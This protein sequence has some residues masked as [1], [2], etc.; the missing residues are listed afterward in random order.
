[1]T[2]IRA[3]ALLR[4]HE[5]LAGALGAWTPTMRPRSLGAYLVVRG[6]EHALAARRPDTGAARLLDAGYLEAMID[7]RI[8]PRARRLW[9][10]L[11]GPPDG[12]AYLH[13]DP[14]APLDRVRALFVRATLCDEAG[15]WDTALVLHERHAAALEALGGEPREIAAALARV[16]VANLHRGAYDE[17]LRVAERAVERSAHE[18]SG[19]TH[20]Q[21]LNVLAGA[22]AELGDLDGAL[23]THRELA[24]RHGE[25]APPRLVDVAQNRNN[26][27]LLL[28]SLDRP[29]EALDEATRASE[30]LHALGEPH[31]AEL[32]TST[33]TLAAVH[34]ALGHLDE[35]L[36]LFRSLAA[37]ELARVGREHPAAIAAQNN[38]AVHVLNH[39]DPV[40]ADALFSDLVPA[41]R[42]TFGADHPN[43]LMTVHAASLAAE[44]AGRYEHAEELARDALQRRRAT[45]RIEHPATRA[46]LRRL[47]GLLASQARHDERAALWIAALDE[48]AASLPA[49]H[50][51]CTEARA[52]LA[53]VWHELRRYA[54]AAS[55]F[56][57][58]VADREAALGL[59]H[60]STLAARSNLARA[61]LHAGETLEAEALHQE[62]M[63]TCRRAFG[64]DHDNTHLVEERWRRAR[65]E[66]A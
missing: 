27:A 49:D 36:A 59:E 12:S 58:V 50:A 26:A 29:R 52:G 17:A 62:L 39:G 63:A 5:Q 37:S 6:V 66:P 33:S 7:A 46:S 3:H 42:A 53:A 38:L 10:A 35:A 13:G 34:Q 54:E 32:A 48:C 41:C 18:P 1:M 65:G 51:A 40:E 47:D 55:L 16:A 11:G 9:K 30:A 25:A 23:A 57:A 22:R 20:L 44:R 4:R 2:T 56:R 24:R 8:A 64:P 19:R 61:L 60:P 28:L 14:P 43:A 15:W 45:L 21:A 31:P